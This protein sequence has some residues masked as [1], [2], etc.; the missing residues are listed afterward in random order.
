VSKLNA[1]FWENSLKLHLQLRLTTLK[2]YKPVLCLVLQMNIK[3]RRVGVNRIDG[4]FSIK[5]SQLLN[6]STI[7]ASNFLGMRFIIYYDFPRVIEPLKLIKGFHNPILY[8][9]ISALKFLYI[10]GS[11][12]GIFSCHMKGKHHKQLKVK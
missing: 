11:L 3:F 9:Q 10:S 4:H 7:D 12:S 2:R 8:P 1:C 5:Y 6:F